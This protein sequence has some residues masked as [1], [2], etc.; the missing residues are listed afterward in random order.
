MRAMAARIDPDE[1]AEAVSKDT[2]TN[3]WPDHIGDPEFLTALRR[4]GRDNVHAMVAIFAGRLELA[5]VNPEGALAFADLTAELGIPVS[6]LERGYWVGV[7]S[8]WREWFRL[9]RQESDRGA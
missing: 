3:V 7:R 4:S 1:I 5:N 8:F 9:A 2:A 6:E